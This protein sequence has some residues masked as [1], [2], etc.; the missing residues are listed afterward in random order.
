MP[1][2]IEVKAVLNDRSA[3]E[4]VAAQIADGPAQVIE[5][6]DIFFPC[7]GARL[8]L[9]V[10]SPDQGELIRYERSDLAEMRCSRYLIARTSDPLILL[11]ILDK[12]LGRTGV[13]K[14]VR[15]LYLVGQTRVHLDHVADL[16][17]FLELEVVLRP[18]QSEREGNNIADGLITKLG[19]SR[20]NF[21][22]DAYVDLLA[23][24]LVRE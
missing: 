8:K 16:G 14:K 13:V 7:D 2:N 18:G 9:R 23:R 5:Q 12:T 6:E 24:R 1:S 15:T 20:K 4:A 22:A 17:E 10:F 11:E 3:V 19:I 21:I